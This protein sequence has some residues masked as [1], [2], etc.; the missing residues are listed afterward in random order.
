MNYTPIRLRADTKA[1]LM[2]ALKTAG[3]TAQDDQGNDQ[4]LVSS[5]HHCLVVRGTLY[6]PTGKTLTDSETGT[7]YPEMA[8]VP[9]YHADLLTDDAALETAL[10]A[11]TITPSSPDFVWAGMPAA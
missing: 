3:L 9:G 4:P 6:A 11:V 8:P 2:A 1:D 7:E 5:H 10:A